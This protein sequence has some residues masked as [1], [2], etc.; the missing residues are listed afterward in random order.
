MSQ[1]K[2]ISLTQSL[3]PGIATAEQLMIHN[4]RVSAPKN[5]LNVETGDKLLAYCIKNKHW[6]IFEQADMTV[7][8]KTSRAIAAQILRHKSMQFQ[9][10]SQRYSE[11]HDFEELEWRLQ[12]ATNRQVGDAP[13]E[14]SEE[15][16][17]VVRLAQ[18]VSV[19]AYEE[20]LKAGIA[21]ECAR[22]VLPLNTQ[23]TMYM[24]GS[25]RSWIH[26]FEVRCSPHAQKEH[27]DVA[28]AI[29]DIFMQTFP[30]TAKALG[31]EEP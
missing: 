28:M 21:K 31:Y 24:K 4:A 9:E 6:S 29:R 10:L 12:G 25:V 22:M 16:T 30:V 26:Y 5:Q 8:V 19:K 13:Y 20:L 27:R 23:T 18:E 15:L 2:L 11:V 3:V 14:L 7:E 17:D 1:V